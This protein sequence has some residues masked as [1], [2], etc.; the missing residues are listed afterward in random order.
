MV[1]SLSRC[2]AEV[3]WVE[4]AYLFGSHAQGRARPDSDI[5]VAVKVT[6]D[7]ATRY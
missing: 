4:F 3:P 1:E 5:D 7:P 2:L 6:G